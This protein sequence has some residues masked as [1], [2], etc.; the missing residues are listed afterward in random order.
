MVYNYFKS[1]TL[2]L[3]HLHRSENGKF[4]DEL[5]SNPKIRCNITIGYV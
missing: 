2:F 3:G 1:I 5:Y 4:V